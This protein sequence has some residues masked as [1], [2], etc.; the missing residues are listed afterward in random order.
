MHIRQIFFGIDFFPLNR[1]SIPLVIPQVVEGPGT[2]RHLEVMALPPLPPAHGRTREPLITPPYSILTR[3]DPFGTVG[4]VV[5]PVFKNFPGG[6]ACTV[7]TQMGTTYPKMRGLRSPGRFKIRV[8]PET[9]VA[10]GCS[11]AARTRTQYWSPDMATS[12]NTP[13]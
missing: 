10:F 8:F 4:A 3:N 6:V 5:G 9:Q 2:R 7:L 13:N 11:G 1:R 12:E